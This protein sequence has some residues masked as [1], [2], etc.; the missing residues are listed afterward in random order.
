MKKK[1][2]DTE[3]TSVTAKISPDIKNEVEIILNHL[4]LT[5]SA[6]INILYNQIVLTKS[7]PFEIKLPDKFKI[8]KDNLRINHNDK[9]LIKKLSEK[10]NKDPDKKEKVKNLQKTIKNSRENK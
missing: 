3:L 4:G 7:I 10:V 5:H 1:K 6:I 9:E 2:I 8:N